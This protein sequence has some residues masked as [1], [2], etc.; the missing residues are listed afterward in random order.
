MVCEGRRP[1]D[2]LAGWFF[3]KSVPMSL[4]EQWEC[5]DPSNRKLSIVESEALAWPLW[6]IGDL[7]HVT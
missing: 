3:F 5:F 7:R 4:F 2:W 6:L 1:D